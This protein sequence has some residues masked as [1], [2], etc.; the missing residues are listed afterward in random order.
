M[1]LLTTA[2]SI[3]VLANGIKGVKGVRSEG[4]RYGNWLTKEQAQ[5]LLNA[6]DM[7]TLKGKRDQALLAVLLGCGLRRQEAV[8]L[9]RDHIQQREARWVIVDLVGKRNKVRTVPM[10]S[11]VKVAL[12]N[13][14]RRR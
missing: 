9:R 11:W 12:D 14:K 8:N 2:C 4:I 5:D 7:S 10:A 6:P 3:R 1:K 13:G